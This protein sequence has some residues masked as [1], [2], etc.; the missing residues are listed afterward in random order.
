M[1]FANLFQNA[2]MTLQLT[3]SLFPF[4]LIFVVIFAILQKSNILGE[5]KR[6]FNVVV[7]FI[8]GAMVV[9]PHL[10][11][12]YPPG[13]DIVEIMNAALPQV[14]IVLVAII[15]A[16]LLI[17]ILGGEAKWM[18]GSLS[19]WIAMVA[20]GLIVYIFGAEAGWWRNWPAARN[21]WTSDTSSIVIIIL[22]FAVVIWYITREPTNA[23]KAGAFSESFS[24]LGDMFKK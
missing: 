9:I 2:E 7:A 6:N 4:L 13:K 18:G 12:S 15:M 10:T 24:K 1:G 14:S 5:G 3:D 21:W 23:D 19:G 8:M 22:V 11:R 16:L 20:F 17:G